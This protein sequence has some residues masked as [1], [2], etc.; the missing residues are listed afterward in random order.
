MIDM[1][2]TTEAR[3]AAVIDQQD[4]EVRKQRIREET[5][6]QEHA[7][8]MA[9]TAASM[10]DAVDRARR[11]RSAIHAAAVG[12]ARICRDRRDAL[13]LQRQRIETRIGSLRADRLE[14]EKRRA[15]IAPP[16]PND[17]PSPEEIEAHRQTV[18]EKPLSMAAPWNA[19]TM[20]KPPLTEPP[21]PSWKQGTNFDDVARHGGN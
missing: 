9:A 7:R 18:A 2:L 15:R 20:G 14:I 3:A 16:D 6:R 19:R 5:A 1:T 12:E 4:A 10:A 13:R 17:Y 8:Q 11:R 21:P